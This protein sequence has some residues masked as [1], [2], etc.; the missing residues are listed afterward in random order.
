[1]RL[2]VGG[3]FAQPGERPGPGC[4]PGVAEGVACRPQRVD[5]KSIAANWPGLP[6]GFTSGIDAA[7][8][9]QKRFAGKPYFSKGDQYVRYDW[10]ND[11]TDPGYPQPIIFNW[12]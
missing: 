4:G 3:P 2:G 10:A 6:A 11:K 9:G 12:L 7:F 5:P 1:V 8:N